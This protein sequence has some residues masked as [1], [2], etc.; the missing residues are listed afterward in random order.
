MS[1]G[2]ALLI[3]IDQYPNFEAS[4]QLFGA[5]ADAEVMAHWLVVTLGFDRRDIELLQNHEAG[6]SAVLQSME[7][8]RQRARPGDRLVFFFSGHGS[9]MT[10]REGDEGD[11]LDETLVPHD[12]GRTPAQNRDITDDEIHAWA[13]TVL[14]ITPHLL[15]IFDCC[16]SGTLHRPGWRSRAVPADLRPSQDLPP[17]PMAI[18]N[19]RVTRDVR[20]GPKPLRLSACG[21]D[22]QAWELPPIL[23]DGRARGAFTYHLLRCLEAGDT[24][25]TWREAVDKVSKTFKDTNLEQ[26]PEGSGPAY[27]QPVSEMAAPSGRFPSERKRWARLAERYPGDELIQVSLFRSREGPWQGADT[28]QFREGDRL[29]VDLRHKHKKS[30]YLYLLDLG[31]TAGIGLIFPDLNDHERVDPGIPL[32]I[33]ARVEDCLEFFL[34]EGFVADQGRGCFLVIGSERRVPTSSLLA[35][36]ERLLSAELKLFVVR[37]PYLLSR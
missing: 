5:A 19:D 21:D 27:D 12:S 22:E 32:R 13:A 26:R 14:E 9:Q 3:G 6:R 10:D 31:L 15:L 17:S 24:S 33:G 18:F 4:Y 29:R 28:A 16:H 11:G 35:Q 30:L 36:D 20:I 8:L 25:V 34:P 2:R 1:R 37:I 23:A 7:A